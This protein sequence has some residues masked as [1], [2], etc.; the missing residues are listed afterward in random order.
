MVQSYHLRDYETVIGQIC[1]IP[2]ESWTEEIA[3]LFLKSYIHLY[4]EEDPIIRDLL[5]F[6]LTKTSV[7]SFRWL[8]KFRI[9]FSPSEALSIVG[10]KKVYPDWLDRIIRIEGDFQYVIKNAGELERNFVIQNRTR[11]QICL[12]FLSCLELYEMEWEYY[13][14]Y[15]W[16][17]NLHF[18][19]HQ[20]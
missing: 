6:A 9:D 1:L 20:H 14:L 13:P 10:E 16:L 2:Q 19:S 15:K 4:C 7:I 11:D 17:T 5:F 3:I 18:K 8:G 12:F